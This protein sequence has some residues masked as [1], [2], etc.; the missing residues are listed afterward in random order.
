MLGIVFQHGKRFSRKASL[1]LTAMKGHASCTRWS[2]PGDRKC[3]ISVVSDAPEKVIVERAAF[4]LPR[5]N[6]LLKV[7]CVA[8]IPVVQLR[9]IPGIRKR[10]LLQIFR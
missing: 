2:A 10:M 5:R 6:E 8:R 7:Y 1:T 4:I 3:A 9:D